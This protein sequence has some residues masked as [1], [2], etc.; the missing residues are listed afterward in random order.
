MT[1]HPNLFKLN[2]QICLHFT[3]INCISIIVYDSIS[4]AFSEY[5]LSLHTILHHGKGPKKMVSRCIF[6]RVLKLNPKDNFIPPLRSSFYSALKQN[7]QSGFCTPVSYLFERVSKQSSDQFSP[8]GTLKVKVFGQPT[9]LTQ[10][11]TNTLLTLL[12]SG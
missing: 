9:E 5:F 11:S 10:A 1:S 8:V 7:L 3:L 4:W 12:H 2:W 6:E